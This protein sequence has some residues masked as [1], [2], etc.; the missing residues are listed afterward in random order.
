MSDATIALATC[1]SALL[2]LGVPAVTAID[3]TDFSVAGQLLYNQYDRCRQTLLRMHPWAFATRRLILYPT[4]TTLNSG[5]LTIGA[6][7]QVVTTASTFDI[8]AVNN[9]GVTTDP[10]VGFTFIATGTTPAVWTGGEL[11]V[12]VPFGYSQMFTLPGDSLRLLALAN[13]VPTWRLEGLSIYCN[14]DTISL[15]YLSDVDEVWYSYDFLEALAFFIAAELAPTLV[16]SEDTRRAM[17]Q[18][19]K[20]YLSIAKTRDS[21]EG[22]PQEMEAF[23]WIQSRDPGYGNDRF[24]QFSA[25]EWTPT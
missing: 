3:G 21:Q 20:D 22:G 2:K 8:T 19:F 17:L 5:T 10:V 16:Q 11:Q 18:S 6:R 4:V 23:D 25:Q 9:Q 1:N 13:G 12:L 24:Y 15:I 7:Y 14:A